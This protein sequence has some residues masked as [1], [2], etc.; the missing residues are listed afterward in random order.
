VVGVLNELNSEV[1]IPGESFKKTILRQRIIN[2]FEFNRDLNDVKI[3]V[4]LNFQSTNRSLTL[5]LS[6]P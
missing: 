2:K 4:R 6:S 5:E 1:L 3:F